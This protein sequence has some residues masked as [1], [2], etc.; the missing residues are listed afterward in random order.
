MKTTKKIATEKTLAYATAF[1]FT[2]ECA[3]TFMQSRSI[4]RANCGG[5]VYYVTEKALE[6]LKKQY[7]W[8]C[9]F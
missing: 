5:Y 4:A 1:L 9:D 8:A 3:A 7:S 2:N 6:A